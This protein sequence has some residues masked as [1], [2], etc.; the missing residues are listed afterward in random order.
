MISFAI[1]A[2]ELGDA[3]AAMAH[4]QRALLALAADVDAHH[5]SLH[6]GWTGRSAEAHAST[7]HA[8]REGCADMVSA[9][10]AL[11]AMAAE[12]ETHY[13]GAVAANVGLWD[14]VR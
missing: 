12:A 1:D 4:C 2:D 14:R 3:V 9:L 5:R 7:Q 11:R 8:W 13:R 10:A 6:A